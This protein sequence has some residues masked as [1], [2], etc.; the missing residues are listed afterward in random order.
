MAWKR[1]FYFLLTAVY[2]FLYVHQFIG[3]P[4]DGHYIRG[5]TNNFVVYHCTFFGEKA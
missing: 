1:F 3:Y 4:S 5:V 2:L